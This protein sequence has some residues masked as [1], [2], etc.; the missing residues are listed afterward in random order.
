MIILG[1]EEKLTF[2]NSMNESLQANFW[3][4]FFGEEGLILKI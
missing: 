3:N 2:C 4:V 1:L